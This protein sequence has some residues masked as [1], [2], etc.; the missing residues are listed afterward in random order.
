[1]N[2][3][4]INYQFDDISFSAFKKDL[5]GYSWDFLRRDLL[6]AFGVALMTVPQAMAYA[7]LAGLPLACG[8]FASIFAAMVVPLFSSSRHMIT[9]PTNA[10]A[11]LVQAAVSEVMY[12]YYRHL[13]GTDWDV[14]AVQVLTQLVMLTAFMQILAAVCK[15]GRLIQ[16]VSHS[17]VVGYITGTAIAIIINQSFTFLGVA[18]IEGVHSL[19]EK[20]A[21][22]VAHLSKIHVPTALTGLG[23]LLTVFLLRKIDKRIPGSVLT[24]ILA[25]AAVYAFD[26]SSDDAITGI[27]DPYEDVEVGKVM[28]IGDFG[29]FIEMIPNIS[30]PYFDTGLMNELLPVS[31]ALA[32]LSIL[33]TTTVAKTM[34]AETG[35]RLST[36]QEIL[37]LGLGNTIS[38]FIGALP[39]SGSSIRTSLIYQNGAQTRF[40]GVFVALIAGALF[41]FFNEWISLIPLTALSALML[42]SALSI[43]NPRHF[44]LCLKATSSDAFVLCTT[45]FSCIFFS[46]D[47]AFYI[48]VSLSIILYLK[49]AAVPQ[50]VEYDIDDDGELINLNYCRIREHKPIRVIKVEGELFFGAADLFQTTLRAFAEDD[51][52]TRVLILQLKNTRDIDATTCL[53]LQQLHDYLK[54]S[55]RQLIACGITHQLWEVFS[56]SGL[57]ELIGK[58][59]L[60]VFDERHPHQHM[61]KALARGQQLVGSPLEKPEIIDIPPGLPVT[62]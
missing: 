12:T 39:I 34:A 3:V 31:F 26:L 32:L 40:A 2:F 28:L 6:A 5:T 60:F 43:V 4:T 52:S 56:D 42:F 29:G 17:V 62:L 8:L 10:M 19:Y 55:G 54:N 35:Q 18:D 14:M 46:L 15:L 20:G 33:E 59:H 44:I 50:L 58:E 27:V 48:G 45:L 25:A 1:M 57:V 30:F 24:F 16:F 41:Y 36:N 11:I 61:A 23:C 7:L 13:T 37:S 47:V 38:S 21:Y 53:A 9:G 49:K 22:L 51:T